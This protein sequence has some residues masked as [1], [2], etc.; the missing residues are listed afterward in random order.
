MGKLQ[1][2]ADPVKYVIC[3]ADEGDPGAYMDRSLLEGNPHSVLE[4][5]IIGA[6]AIGSHEG[7]CTCETNTPWPSSTSGW[8]SSRPRSWGSSERTSSVRASILTSRSPRGRRLCL[9]RVFCPCRFHRRDVGRAQGPSTSIL[10]KAACGTSHQPQQRGDLG[11]RACHRRQRGGLVQEDRTEGSKGTK[12]FS[13]VGKVN[14][15]GLVEVPMGIS[16]REII[17]DMGEA[18]PEGKN[19]RPCRPAGPRAD[20][21]PSR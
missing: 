2:A 3:N 20:V 7:T 18:S 6:F 1:D 16:L 5:M 12:I 15:T 13:L 8:P 4:G 19:S 10:W 21:S 11:Q 9:R 14:N 17:Y